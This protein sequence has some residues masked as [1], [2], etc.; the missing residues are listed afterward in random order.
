MKR[1]FQ[2]R[3]WEMDLARIVGDLASAAER[4]AG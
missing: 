2:T 4:H 1:G 3:D